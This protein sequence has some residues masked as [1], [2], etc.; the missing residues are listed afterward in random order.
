MVT[1]AKITTLSTLSAAD[2]EAAVMVARRSGLLMAA[3]VGGVIDGAVAASTAAYR[4]DRRLPDLSA[5][6]HA[7][8][9]QQQ[10]P[11]DG[12]EA[13][14]TAL[15]ARPMSPCRSRVAND[16]IRHYGG[17]AWKGRTIGRP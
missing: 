8:V 12:F 4:Q 13:D 6:C 1:A 10:V 11:F 9:R 16:R 17:D 3:P 5:A 2:I 7:I 15:R 14:R